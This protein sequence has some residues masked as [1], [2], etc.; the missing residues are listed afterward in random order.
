MIYTNT[1]VDAKE[2]VSTECVTDW[3]SPAVCEEELRALFDTFLKMNICDVDELHNTIDKAV[4]AY[5]S[6]R[7]N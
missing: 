5:V 6:G 3:E 1:I 4:K 7:T 2:K